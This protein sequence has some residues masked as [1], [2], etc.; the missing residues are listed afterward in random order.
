MSSPR[1]ELRT[2]TDYNCLLLILF[3][4]TKLGVSEVY[5]IEQWPRCLRRGFGG[6]RLLELRTPAQ[7][8]LFWLLC[9]VR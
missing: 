3:R 9:V 8:G 2:L 4:Q 6:A 5:D 1:L 7:G